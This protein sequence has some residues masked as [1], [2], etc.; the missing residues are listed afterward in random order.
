MNPGGRSTRT[1]PLLPSTAPFTAGKVSTTTAGRE[2]W[3]GARSV[4]RGGRGRPSLPQSPP[5]ELQLDRVEQ[6]GGQQTDRQEERQGPGPSL[7]EAASPAAVS[8]GSWASAAGWVPPATSEA[9]AGCNINAAGSDT[10]PPR[11]RQGSGQHR[12]VP[13]VGLCPAQHREPRQES[14]V[15]GVGSSWP[16]LA[17]T[18]PPRPKLG[19]ASAPTALPGPLP[20]G[21]RRT[22]H[23]WDREGGLGKAG[24]CH[25]AAPRPLP[26][27]GESRS[28]PHSSRGNDS[29]G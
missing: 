11:D 17:L 22:Q 15:L 21:W 29:A 4:S 14:E 27:P 18:G 16:R 12:M 3:E 5:Q 2:F 13:T 9:S 8:P 7:T 28:L 10:G 6:A 20:S 1:A 24:R 26:A 23:S 25:L 19:P